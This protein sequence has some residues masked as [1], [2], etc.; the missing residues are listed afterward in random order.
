MEPWIVWRLASSL[1]PRRA[2]S[3][4]HFGILFRA[5][6][7]AFMAM[8][9]FHWHVVA[10]IIRMF[11]SVVDWTASRAI[12]TISF[13]QSV[14]QSVCVCFDHQ[15]QS[16]RSKVAPL[17]PYSSRARHVL[18]PLFHDHHHCYL[19]TKKGSMIL[20]DCAPILVD[21]ASTQFALLCVDRRE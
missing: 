9:I 11:S 7:L 14:S 3:L 20:V 16:Y 19:V 18:D 17:F 4:Q 8:F 2:R 1:A 13:S 15:C 6:S 21:R 10:I 12:I 5:R